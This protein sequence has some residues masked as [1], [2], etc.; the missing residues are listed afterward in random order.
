MRLKTCARLGAAAVLLVGLASPAVAED[1]VD[2]FRS[3]TLDNGLKVSVLA[4]P[5]MPIVATQLWVQVGSAHETPEEQGFAHLFEHLMFGATATYDKEAY[6]RHHTRWGG[7]E[8]AYTSFDNTVYISEI[9]PEAHDQVLVFEADRGRNLI[10]SAENLANEQKIVTEELRLRTENDPFSR[11][12]NPALKALFGEHPYGHSPAGTKEDIADADLELVKKFYAG[13]YHPQNMHLVVVGPVDPDATVARVT[14]LFGAPA[15]ERLV[16]PTVPP[17]ATLDMPDQVALSED[18]PPIRVAALVYTGPTRNDPDWWAWKLMTELLAGGEQ[19]LFREELVTRRGKAVEAATLAEDLRAGAILAFGSLSLPLR[20]E[21]RCFSLLEQTRDTLDEGAW[22][23]QEGLD[24]A[25][26]RLLRAELERSYYAA[27]MA[28]AI[29][30][31]WAWQGDDRLGV[32]GAGA[33]LDAVTLEQVRGVWDRYIMQ[34]SPTRF[35]LSKGQ[36]GTGGVE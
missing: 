36:A 21:R 23:T 3:V 32:T 14:E 25:R 20:S 33:A 9:A 11:L 2:G 12:L 1:P 13:Y 19:D 24:T 28:D 4:D 8:N 10:L 30:Q 34:G 29:G 18:I 16:P 26:R 5:D 31:A 6:S 15:G 17:L 35:S 7:S 27:S 22:L